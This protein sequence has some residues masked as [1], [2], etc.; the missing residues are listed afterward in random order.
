MSN[1]RDMKELCQELGFRLL[2]GIGVGAEQK[3]RLLGGGSYRFQLDSIMRRGIPKLPGATRSALLFP[4]HGSTFEL[5]TQAVLAHALALR[6]VRPLM[7]LCDEALPACDRKTVVKLRRQSEESI[8]RNCFHYGADLLRRFRLP[9]VTF[10]EVLRSAGPLPPI[11]CPDEAL[12]SFTEGGV[13]LGEIA[14]SSAMRYYQTGRLEPRPEVRA[15]LRRYLE[16]ARKTQLVAETL[17][18]RE[19]ADL[20][21]MTHGIYV[22]WAPALEVARLR[23]VPAVV[24]DE[25]PIINE[26]LILDWNVTTHAYVL[27]EAWGRWKDRDLSTDQ[28]RR[29]E[30]YLES[31]RS[32]SRDRHKYNFAPVENRETACRKA[33]LDPNRPVFG[34]FPNLLWDGACIDRDLSFPSQID[35][36]IE[37][38]RYFGRRP[39]LQLVVKIHPAESVVGTE[40]SIQDYIREALPTLPANVRLVQPRTLN[41]Y[42]VYNLISAGLVHTSTVGLEMS[43]LGIPVVVASKTHY[44]G[45]GFTHDVTNPEEYFRAIDTAAMARLAPDQV[46]AARKYAYLFFMGHNIPFRYLLKAPEGGH[47]VG[48][49]FSSLEDLAPGK[50]PDLDFICDRILDGGEFVNA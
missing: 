8:C 29:L 37:T 4:I 31:R 49:N 40:R 43:L 50:D 9:F 18:D 44:R 42:S 27:D 16:A 38:I 11:E 22:S 12:G 46:R 23:R 32:N 6:G 33:D 15:Q 21:L 48:F 35:W 19:R 1:G 36:A 5:A 41:V 47:L 2:D 13:R 3:V 25:S 39:D 20:F 14:V 45:R 24:F 17:L 26:C 34:L 28:D 7:V 10:S 30:D